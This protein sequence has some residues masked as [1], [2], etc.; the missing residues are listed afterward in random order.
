MNQYVLLTLIASLLFACSS[1]NKIDNKGLN[2][3]D[4]IETQDYKI[5]SRSVADTVYAF[6][7][8]DEKPQMTEQVWPEYPASARK[9]KI[10]GVV[11][12]SVIIDVTG[13]VIHAEIYKSVPGLDKQSLEAAKKLKFIPARHDGKI[14]KVKM[15][16]PFNFRLK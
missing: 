14:V 3:S 2:V 7:E 15:N 12:V 10:E 8:V 16:I 11:V 1:I 13:D 6:Y 4:S 9:E 5:I